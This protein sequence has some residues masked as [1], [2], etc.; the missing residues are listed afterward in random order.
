MV[1]E[2]GIPSIQK[3]A[4]HLSRPTDR[5]KTEYNKAMDHHDVEDLI[6]KCSTF[7]L[8]LWLRLWWITTRNQE[9]NFGPLWTKSSLIGKRSGKCT[10]ME[11]REYECPETHAKR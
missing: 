1:S 9:T 7:D 5:S 8:D 4:F 11:I 6:R 10:A 2:I 3:S